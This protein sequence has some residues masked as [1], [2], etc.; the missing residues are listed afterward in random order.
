MMPL[1]PFGGA[2]LRFRVSTTWNPSGLSIYLDTCGALGYENEPYWEVY[3]V[4]GD[5]LRLPF[6]KIVEL[7]WCIINELNIT[8]PRRWWE[9]W[10][11]R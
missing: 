6:E 10:R 3:P 2:M 1:P 8:R 7:R 11:M 4:N 9:F 5:T